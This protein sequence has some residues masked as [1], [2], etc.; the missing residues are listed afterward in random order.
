MTHSTKAPKVRIGTSG[1]AYKHW[2]GKFYPDDMKADDYLSFYASEF[3]TAEINYS[4]YKLP[5]A[6]NYTNWARD[7]G[8]DFIFAV[9]GSRYLTHMKK[10]KDPA[11]PW[12]KICAT[13]GVLG[14][15]LGPVLMQFPA[16]WSK[17]VDRL[18]E[19]LECTKNNECEQDSNFRLAFEFRDPSWFCSE[20]YKILEAYDAALCIADS[21]DFVRKDVVTT[22]FIYIRYHGRK[23]I[24]AANYSNREL[25]TEAKKIRKFLES[26]SD[27]FAYFNNDGEAHAIKNARRL[28]ELLD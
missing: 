5:S 7:V 15:K 22:D 13:A 19:F 12:H 26:G 16:H 10:L 2:L 28:R 6:E 23:P 20:V 18:R 1:W 27:V 21:L 4:F 9:K 8:D 17:N 24:Y 3:E 25:T 11:D 14:H